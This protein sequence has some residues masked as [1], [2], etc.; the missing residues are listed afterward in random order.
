[1]AYDDNEGLTRDE[2]ILGSV[3]AVPDTPS[4][5]SLET[6]AKNQIKIA[7]P[8]FVDFN[9]EQINPLNLETIQRLFFE[10]I[11]GQE[12]IILSNRN[13]VNFQNISYQPISGVL[14]F[15]NKY[16]P[17]KIIALQDTSDSYFSNFGIN[18]DLK[19][20]KV[21]SSESTNNTNVYMKSDGN[22]IVELVNLESDER[23][24]IQIL[25]N[26][27]IYEDIVE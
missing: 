10:D 19:I 15:K 16:D 12:L 21:V 3:N 22:I 6:K 13:F 2:T 8:Q 11:N 17:K 23:I 20:P 18:L 1:M 26:G 24:E 25:L 9:E 27:T 7:E 5:L 4:N 14:N